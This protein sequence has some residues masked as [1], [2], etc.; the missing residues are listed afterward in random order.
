MRITYDRAAN[1]AYIHLTDRS[2]DS[3]RNTVIAP[4]P[5]DANGTAIL[6]WKD[7]HLVGIEILDADQAL[8]PDLLE[9]AEDITNS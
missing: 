2:L 9:Q 5:D 1:A 7:G 4:T 8:D 3:G 6:D